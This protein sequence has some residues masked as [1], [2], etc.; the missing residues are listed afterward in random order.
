M[1][2]ACLP[3]RRIVL[4]ILFVGYL[5][6]LSGCNDESRT[7]GTMVRESD[8]T[9]DYRKSKLEAYKGGPPKAKAKAPAGNR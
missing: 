2:R 9:K 3:R 1:S 7:T 5:L 6:P 4:L 8:E